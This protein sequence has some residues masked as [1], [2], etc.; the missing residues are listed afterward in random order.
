[1][2]KE[3]TN[4][5]DNLGI[6]KRPDKHWLFRAGRLLLIIC[7]VLA[8]PFLFSFFSTFGDMQAG[9]LAFLIILSV[10]VLASLFMILIGYLLGK[11]P[12]I[13]GMEDKKQLVFPLKTKFAAWWLILL[14]IINSFT[15][16]Y[17][18]LGGVPDINKLYNLAEYAFLFIYLIPFLIYFL[19]GTFILKR[20]RRVWWIAIVSLILT[21][22]LVIGTDNFLFYTNIFL[23]SLDSGEFTEQIRIIATFSFV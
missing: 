9:P 23:F 14:A 3:T 8:I 7:I 18:Y 10:P 4:Q 5:E 17:D 16:S 15:L 1:M 20:K 13:E 19:M 22:L 21:L 6:Q 2:N 12:V 11:N